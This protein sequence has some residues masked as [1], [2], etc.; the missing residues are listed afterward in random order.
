MRKRYTLT[1][2]VAALAVM[3]FGTTGTGAW[4]VA[5]DTSADVTVTSGE[6]VVEVRGP[7]ASP[8]SV[9]PL[10]PGDQ[11]V[12]GHRMEI[13]NVDPDTAGS[14]TAK[15]R[16]QDVKVSASANAFYND[17]TVKVTHWFAGGPFND[18]ADS[19]LGNVIYDGLL[20]DLYAESHDTGT[21]TGNPGFIGNGLLGPN[22]THVFCV[23]FGLDASA[24][25]A[26]MN[27]TAVTQ[28]KV[29]ATQANNPGW[30]Q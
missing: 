23:Y 13:Y 24:G 10:F 3:A 22:I 26:A 11:E 8:V 18:C 25:N 5:S 30:A 17:L 6:L 21:G 4:F 29:D 28:V 27:Q 14:P 9:G 12:T 1:L 2:A 19:S 15:Y 20:K 16:F 7:L